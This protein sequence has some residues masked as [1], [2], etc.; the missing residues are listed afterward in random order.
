MSVRKKEK[1]GLSLPQQARFS[2]TTGSQQMLILFPRNLFFWIMTHILPSYHSDF[3]SNV[4][5]FPDYPNQSRS[6]E[7]LSI[8]FPLPLL[9]LLVLLLYKYH[10]SLFIVY[11]LSRL[12]DCKLLEGKG[13]LVCSLLLPQ[14]QK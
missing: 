13:C 9:L 2:S 14:Y 8:I 7:L 4:I 10:M 5:F 3:N 6:W 12:L 11:F 1:G